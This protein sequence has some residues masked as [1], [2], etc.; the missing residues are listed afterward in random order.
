VPKPFRGPA[1][2]DDVDLGVLPKARPRY[3]GH[4][5]PL[6]DEDTL[7]GVKAALLAG[8]YAVDLA[9]R[10]GYASLQSFSTAFRRRVGL[11]PRRFAAQRGVPRPPARQTGPRCIGRTPVDR[12]DHVPLPRYDAKPKKRKRR[13]RKK[14]T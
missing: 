7:A 13:R 11:T 5:S 9:E 3:G 6:A 8:A 2:F 4:P 1:G 14:K 10:C 12:S